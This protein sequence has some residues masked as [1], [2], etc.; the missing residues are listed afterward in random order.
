MGRIAAVCQGFDQTHSKG[1]LVKTIP[2]QGS[3]A[4][5]RV[6]PIALLRSAITVLGLACGISSAAA[7]TWTIT[8][9]AGDPIGG[10]AAGAVLSNQY[11]ASTGATFTPNAFSGAGGPTTTWATNTNMIVVSSTG[12]DVGGLGT[13][14][15]VSGNILRSFAGWLDEDGDPSMRMTLSPPAQN[16]SVTFAGVSTVAD[17][18]L[19][20][21]DAGGIQIGATV[22]GTGSAGQQT[23]T[24]NGGATPI[25]SVAIVPGSFNDWVGIDNITCT[26]FVF[27]APV[28]LSAVIRKTHGVAGP[29]DLP[30]SLTPTTPSTESR[31]GPSH[32]LVLTFNK[33][34]ISGMFGSSEGT[35]IVGLGTTAGNDVLLDYSGVTDKQYVTFT[36]TNFASADGGVLPSG[37]VRVGFLFGDVN[38]S[39]QVTVADVGIV[40]GS[41]LQPVTAANFFRDV[42]VDGRLTVADKGLTNS[43]LLNKLPAP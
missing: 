5:A 37:S 22:A 16:C 25:A 20:A 32:T 13:P 34:I 28:L 10:L 12:T 14:A 4:F 31:A 11:T 19:L 33:P 26:Q 18:R 40:N 43:V 15:L 2:V 29:F 24:I 38:Q 9:D 6:S 27:P 1:S 41:L 21:F 17:I 42:N 8:F 30:L 36:I 35:A 23:L 39:R 3:A 7:A